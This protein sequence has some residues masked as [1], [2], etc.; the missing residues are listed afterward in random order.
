MPR[1]R[2]TRRSCAREPQVSRPLCAL[3]R[4][5]VR[6]DAATDQPWKRAHHVPFEGRRSRFP[7]L[8][9]MRNTPTRPAPIRSGVP[10]RRTLPC[11][12]RWRSCRPH[13]PRRPRAR[14]PHCRASSRRSLGQVLD[15][16]LDRVDHHVPLGQRLV[17]HRDLDRKLLHSTPER[18]VGDVNQIGRSGLRDLVD[19]GDDGLPLRGRI[20]EPGHVLDLGARVAPVR[21]ELEH[22]CVCRPRNRKAHA[23]VARGRCRLV[24]AAL[25]A[26]V[27]VLR[28]VEIVIRLDPIEVRE[29]TVLARPDVAQIDDRCELLGECLPDPR[30]WQGRVDRVQI[31]EDRGQRPPESLVLDER[32]DVPSTVESWWWSGG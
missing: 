15:A 12:P 16:V 18:V 8:R 29:R 3:P 24:S 5:R 7:A 20:G 30:I 23:G 14:R 17:R 21:R 10:T 19:L 13:G 1:P 32:G 31:D 11:P 28:D 26:E 27:L 4:D 22:V 6:S 9:E 25:V 2:A